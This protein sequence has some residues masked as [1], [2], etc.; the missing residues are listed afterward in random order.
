MRRRLDA[1]V[2]AQLGVDVAQAP[3]QR[4]YVARDRE[5][6]P[7]RVPGGGVG[8]L[9]DHQHPDVG[10]RTLEG[11]QDRVAGR[12]VGPPGGELRAQ[13]PTHRGEL[14]VDRGERLGPVGGHQTLVHETGQGTHA[15]TVQ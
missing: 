8:V 1:D 11:A 6:Q 5:R 13:E 9:A 15:G 12:Q 14:L 10:E 3:G 4:T 7:D 2:G